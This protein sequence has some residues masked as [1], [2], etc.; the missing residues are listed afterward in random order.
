MF[1]LRMVS[2]S[3]VFK[4][5]T[6]LSEALIL[7]EEEFEDLDNAYTQEFAQ[8]FV[9]ELKFLQSKNSSKEEHKPKKTHTDKK[10]LK[11]IHKKLA[12]ATHP[13]VSDGKDDEFKRIQAAYEAGD[14]PTLLSASIQHNVEI[15]LTDAEI[16][17]M[18]ADIHSRRQELEERKTALRWVWCQ[19]DK[20]IMLR[21]KVLF[22]LNINEVDLKKWAAEQKD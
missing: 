18:M 5:I 4:I 1:L 21:D 12:K 16:K 11:K 22:F 2:R 20:S 8:D 13:D 7:E 17:T 14:G 6:H 10:I 3:R 9:L 15:E 19:S